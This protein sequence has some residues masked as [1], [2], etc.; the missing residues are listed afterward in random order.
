M[1]T[2]F[3]KLMERAM[4]VSEIVADDRLSGM[5]ETDLSQYNALQIND[6][7][8]RYADDTA[9]LAGN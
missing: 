2:C 9:L 4:K 8:L 5:V 3:R 1:E 6:N 7:T